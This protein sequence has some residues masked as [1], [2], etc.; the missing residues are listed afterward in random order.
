MN[1]DAVAR[2]YGS[3]TP[4]ERFRLIEAAVAREYDALRRRLREV[5]GVRVG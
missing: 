2:H 4:E 1:A 3:L 5:F